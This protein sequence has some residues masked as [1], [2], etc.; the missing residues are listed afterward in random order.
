MGC[1]IIISYT[2]SCYI[3]SSY[4][5]GRCTTGYYIISNYIISYYITTR[6]CA[7]LKLL[8]VSRGRF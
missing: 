6:P 2:T 1:C 7:I 5:I 4:I 3:I 8:L